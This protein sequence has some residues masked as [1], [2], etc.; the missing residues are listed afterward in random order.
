MQWTAQQLDI[1][2]KAYNRIYF[3][4][5]IK[6]PIYVFWSKTLFNSHSNKNGYCRSLSDRHLIVLNITHKNASDEVMRSLLVHEM[7]HAW[8]NEYDPHRNDE[9]AKYRGHGPSFQQKCAE[10]NAKFKFR[11]P[12]AR[13]AS[14]RHMKSIQKTNKD[15]FYV[16]KMT[17]NPKLPGQV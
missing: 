13:Y 1:R 10:L 2:A 9:W 7:I 5:E 11:Y 4:N 16:Y 12:L 3:N 14:T 6:K 8:Q 17:T 15:V